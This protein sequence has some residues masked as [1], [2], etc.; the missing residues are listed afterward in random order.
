MPK[1]N[2]IQA[3]F[4]LIRQQTVVQLPEIHKALGPVSHGTVCRKL[5]QTDVQSSYSH[6][7]RYYTLKELAN[8]DANGIWTYGD[9]R[10]SKHGPLTTT[11]IALVDQSEAGLYARDLQQM[12]K[13]DVL[14]SLSRLVHAGRIARTK[15]AER[16]LYVSKNRS[17][18]R[19]QLRHRTMPSE[20]LSPAFECAREEWLEVLD[21]RQRRLYAGLESLRTGIGGDQ[22]VATQLGMARATVAKGRKQLLSGEFEKDRV[23]KP[24]GGRKPVEKKLRDPNHYSANH[25]L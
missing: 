10:F 1:S 17:R 24:G 3:V 9:I 15:I 14:S 16:Y 19:I 6:R 22:K 20:V 12:V 25:R 13:L 2:S 7:G 11:L 23:R 8:F 21:E 5:A 4:F 18:R